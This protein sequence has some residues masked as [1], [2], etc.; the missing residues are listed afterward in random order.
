MSLG[1]LNWWGWIDDS[2]YSW[3][4]GF[5]VPLKEIEAYNERIKD[6]GGSHQ[7]NHPFTYAREWI[8]KFGYDSGERD[9]YLRTNRLFLSLD[10]LAPKGGVIGEDSK[11]LSDSDAVNPSSIYTA[12]FERLGG[13][14]E[15][16]QKKLWGST[17]PVLE[18]AL[19]KWDALHESPALMLVGPAEDYEVNWRAWL[20]ITRMTEDEFKAAFYFWEK[21]DW[22]I[23]VDEGI[24]N[25]VKEWLEELYGK[26]AGSIMADFE[27]MQVLGGCD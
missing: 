19:Q 8:R 17:Y 3:V 5:F 25:A 11:L 16:E 24:N 9:K 2:E 1:L 18:L 20:P 4:K 12:V 23:C 13:R 7:V 26:S 6:L 21:E 15:D 27:E 14:D 22:W 10:Y